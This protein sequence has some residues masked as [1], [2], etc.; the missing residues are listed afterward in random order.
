MTGAIRRIGDLP[1]QDDGRN[2]RDNKKYWRLTPT[3][4][5]GVGQVLVG[6]VPAAHRPTSVDLR[7]GNNHLVVW[8]TA[9]GA[10][11][12]IS[13]LVVR[14]VGTEHLACILWGCRRLALVICTYRVTTFPSQ[15]HPVIN[16]CFIDLSCHHRTFHPQTYSVMQ[17]FPLDIPSHTFALYACCVMQICFI[18]IPRHATFPSKTSSC[19]DLC[20]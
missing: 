15:T 16:I 10:L 8:M 3:R 9:D 5:Q 7:G 14:E 13:L 6:W 20:G 2:D 18:C 12:V 4:R 1:P 17:H 19:C 11:A